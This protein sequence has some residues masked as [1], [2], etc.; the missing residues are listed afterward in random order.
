MSKHPITSLLVLLVSLAA[1]PALLAQTRSHDKA[2]KA[3]GLN[4]DALKAMDAAMQKQIDDKQVAGVIGLIGCK[5][6]VGYFEAF[7]HRNIKADKP[8]TQD[9]LFRI[10]SMTKPMVAVTAMS[11]WEEGKFKLDDPISNYCPEWKNV[12]VNDGGKKVPVN[13]PITAR[14]LMTH[15]SG[16]SYNKTNVDLGPTTSLKT[17][18]E[19]LA[20]QPLKFQ[21]GTGYQYGYSI[22]ILGRYIEAIEGKPLD[23]VMRER[24]FDML[25]MDDTEFW[26]RKSED[27]D[28]VALVYIKD[29][30]NNFH[31]W[32][33]SAELLEKPS[34]MMGG[35]GLVSTTADYAKFCQMFLNKG[36]LGEASIL[37]ASTVELMSQ[38]HLKSIGKVYGL[39]RT[40]KKDGFYSWGGAA[41]TGFWIDPATDSFAVFMIQRW[42][43]KPPTYNVFKKFTAQAIDFEDK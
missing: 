42:G 41:G 31:A 21:P 27:L 25:G 7:G 18:S 23:V 34:R 29:K 2:A 39:G 14:H 28:R 30:Q 11:L 12:T 5:G 1:V 43:Y 32:N 3:A 22:D 24:L 38:N 40:V 4:V 37:K 8:M 17:F 10:Y 9:A 15:S 16:L 36:K 13:T 6:K 19:S 35:Q 26:I 20:R 33:K